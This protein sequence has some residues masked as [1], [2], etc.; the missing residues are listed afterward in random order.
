MEAVGSSETSV[1][2]YQNTRGNIPQDTISFLFVAV[3]CYTTK[4]TELRKQNYFLY[5]TNIN[6]IIIIIILKPVSEPG[7]FVAS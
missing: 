4:I 3:S 2:V 1:N 5:I 7:Y 6:I